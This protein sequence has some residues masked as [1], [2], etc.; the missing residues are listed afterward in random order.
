VIDAHLWAILLIDLNTERIGCG[1][2]SRFHNEK[3]I[4]SD[5]AW[6]KPAGYLVNGHVKTLIPD[7]EIAFLIG[8]KVC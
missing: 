5:F 3:D 7:A 6:F 4:V 8:I 1:G 2:E